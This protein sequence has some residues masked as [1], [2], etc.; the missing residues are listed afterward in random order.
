M[1]TIISLLYLEYGHVFPWTLKHSWLHFLGKNKYSAV[2]VEDYLH[3]KSYRKKWC[4]LYRWSSFNAMCVGEL[5]LH[6]F[7]TVQIFVLLYLN[8]FNKIIIL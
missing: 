1:L 4:T 2:Q 6:W 5:A 7:S 3:S 8:W